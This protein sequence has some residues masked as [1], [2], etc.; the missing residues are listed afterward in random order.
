MKIE[1]LN[2]L[3]DFECKSL[4]AEETANRIL[5]LFGVSNWPTWLS[6]DDFEIARLYYKDNKKLDAIKHL[7]SIA[8]PHIESPI[9]WAKNFVEDCC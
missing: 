1:I 7:A 2:L 3:K 9:K 6:Q 5:N 8:R 4:T